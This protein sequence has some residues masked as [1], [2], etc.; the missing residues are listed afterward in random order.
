MKRLCC[1]SALLLLLAG[2]GR[3]TQV[4]AP[5]GSSVELPVIMYHSLVTD[6]RAAAPYVCPIS[7]VEGDLRWLT[8]NGYQSVSLAQ[9]IAF[10]NGQGT[11]PP[12]PVLI[13]LDDGYRNNLTLLPP[14]LEQYDACAVIAV[15]GDVGDGIEAVY[16]MGVKAVFSIN[17]VA[18]PYE[19]ARLRAK[20]DLQETVT[21]I[22]RLLK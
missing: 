18:V 10:A 7:R 8:E 13:T 14:L 6:D 2:C 19:Q 4:F 20:R 12:K 3:Q 16:D 9:L 11:L 15:V 17:R 5:R 22:M 21:D 1:L